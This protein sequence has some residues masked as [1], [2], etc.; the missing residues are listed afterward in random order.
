[1]IF[2]NFCSFAR[3]RHNFFRS[4]CFVRK[5]YD[6]GIGSL[7]ELHCTENLKQYS[8]KWYC[9][10]SLPISTFMYRWVIYIIYILMI[11]PHILLYC[12]CWPIVW[13]YKSLTDIW[14][15]KLGT[16]P[17]SFISGNSCFEFSV[18][19]ICCARI[20]YIRLFGCVILLFLVRQ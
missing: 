12:V 3:T 9:A 20:L 10:V 8:Q 13:I 5:K 18:H 17:C 15:W 19:C 1:M 6:L 11:G 14:M 4:L 7:C 2:V 16:R